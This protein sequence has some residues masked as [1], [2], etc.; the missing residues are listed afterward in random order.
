MVFL[1][2]H[3]GNHWGLGV[4]FPKNTDGSFRMHLKWYDSSSTVGRRSK[5]VC[6]ICWC[7]GTFF[8]SLLLQNILGHLKREWGV[9]FGNEP[10]KKITEEDIHNIPKQ[11]K[12][13]EKRGEMMRDNEVERRQFI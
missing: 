4:L 13:C 3:S 9:Y 10:M 2:I 1:P 7:C 12:V 6:T 5:A 11:G 8:F